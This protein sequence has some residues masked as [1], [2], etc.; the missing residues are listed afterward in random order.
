MSNTALNRTGIC[1]LTNKSGGAVAQGD[2]VIIDGTTAS[3]FTTTTTAAFVAGLVGVVLEPNGIGANAVGLVATSG[4]VPKV[5]LS[6]AATLGDLIATHSVA[7]Q[8]APHAA[9]SVAGD[10]GQVLAASATPAA[11]IFGLPR[12]V[13]AAGDVA[14]DAIWDAAGDIVQGTGSNTA[15][16]LAIG[17]AFQVPR[18][19]AGATALEYAGGI[20]LISSTLVG[21]GGAASVDIQNIPATFKHLRLLYAA[22]GDTVATTADLNL[23]INNDSTAD[24]YQYIYYYIFGNG[25]N[26]TANYSSTAIKLY[27]IP[28]ASATA[29]G[30][31]TGQ[32]DIMHYA[33]TTFLKNVEYHG[34]FMASTGNNNPQG[35]H[36]HACWKSTSAI[37]RLTLTPSAGNLVEG[38]RVSLYGIS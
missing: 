18:V 19:N 24:H 14:T 9:P 10:F 11:I 16:R 20:T 7:K 4:Y 21:A 38:S 6:G 27:S 23:T 35:W 25:N 22:R 12:G 26:N 13:S 2:V 34:T 32:I 15:G 33:G 1:L 28:A 31:G 3:S 5:T 37:S 17:T 8:A 36:G 30:A 29:G